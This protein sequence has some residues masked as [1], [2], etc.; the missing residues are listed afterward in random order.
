MV[1]LTF[2]PSNFVT[3]ANIDLDDDEC[4]FSSLDISFG[5]LEQAFL[6]RD[7]SAPKR[8]KKRKTLDISSFFTPGLSNIISLLFLTDKSWYSNKLLTQSSFYALCY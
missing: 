6:C 1:F 7:D 3:Q 2:F 8:G 4:C 5:V